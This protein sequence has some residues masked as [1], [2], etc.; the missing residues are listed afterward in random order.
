MFTTEDKKF[1]A[2][3]IITIKDIYKIIREYKHSYEVDGNEY[4]QLEKVFKGLCSHSFNLDIE[5]FRDY[6]LDIVDVML[7]NKLKEF[8]SEDKRYK[9][10]NSIYDCIRELYFGE[11]KQ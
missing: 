10:W 11:N 4:V 3:C 6:L 1:L 7:D 9:V 2:N 8:Q 5:Q